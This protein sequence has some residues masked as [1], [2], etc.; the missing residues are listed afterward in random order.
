MMKKYG[1]L[2]DQMAKDL[3]KIARGERS[4]YLPIFIAQG[5]VE[6]DP[7]TGKYKLTEQGAN[8]VADRA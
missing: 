6:L 7:A 8:V 4:E 3:K 5:L 1:T 2:T